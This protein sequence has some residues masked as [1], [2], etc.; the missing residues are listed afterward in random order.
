M[1][2]V[3]IKFTRPQAVAGMS[4]YREGEVA[5]FSRQLA[6]QIIKAGAGVP[7]TPKAE[8]RTTRNKQMDAG[9]SGTYATK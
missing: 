3:A 6:D 2:I 4:T 9:E 1:E 7:Y 5:G 8:K